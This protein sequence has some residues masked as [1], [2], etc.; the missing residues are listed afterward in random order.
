MK[1]D[2]VQTGDCLILLPEIPPESI[3]VCFADPPFNLNK[4]YGSSRDNTDIGYYG[5]CYKWLEHLIRITKPTGSIFI[6]NTPKRLVQIGNYLQARLNFRAWIAWDAPT[7]STRKGLLPSHY[8][9]LWYVK[10]DD[11]KCFNIRAPHL[12]C[13][14]CNSYLKDYGGK[15]HLRNQVGYRLSDIWTDIHRIR[16]KVRRDEHPCQLPIAL[17]ERL[18][19]LTTES[20]DIIL[21]PFLGT[22]TTAIAAKKLGR[23]FIGIDID[24]AYTRIAVDKLRHI[25][26]IDNNKSVYL[27]NTITIKER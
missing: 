3:D 5:W 27:N 10:S 4:R 17:L 25:S 7:A 14:K 16:H 11:Y 13:R 21:D 19:L 22:G 9:I 12:K 6:H 8:G 24:K 2:V 18:I 1:L 15:E 23:H 20:N 26:F